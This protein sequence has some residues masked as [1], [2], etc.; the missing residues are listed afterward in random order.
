MIARIGSA[1][2]FKTMTSYRMTGSFEFQQVGPTGEIKHGKLGEESYTN[3]ARTYARMAQLTREQIINDDLGAL[4]DVPRE[5]GRGAVDKLNSVFWTEFLDNSAFFSAT[6]VTTDMAKVAPNQTASSPLGSAGLTA[7]KTLFI[8]QVKPDGTPINVMP[9]AIVVPPELLDP[10]TILLRDRDLRDNTANKNYVAANPHAGSNLT[11]VTSP[12]LSNT[13]YTGNS[14][15]SWY[16]IANPAQVPMIEVV[17]LNGQQSPVIEQS[18]ADFN[19]LGI[20]MRG[21]FDFGVAKQD[22][23]GAVKATA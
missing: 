13:T 20:Q 8:K 15:T 11:I 16:L 23:R 3:R 21:Y 7:A 18:D 1:N 5:I 17:F 19:V 4:T 10:V 9:Y 6:A 12:Y 14:A 2:D 22:K